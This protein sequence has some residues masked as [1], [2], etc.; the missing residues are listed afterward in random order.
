M[1]VYDKLVRD[2]IPEILTKKGK[3]YLAFR[4]GDEQIMNYLA[5]KLFMFILFHI[6]PSIF[7]IHQGF[8]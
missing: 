8:L 1:T 4:A 7:D 3:S 6:E 5:K 2:K